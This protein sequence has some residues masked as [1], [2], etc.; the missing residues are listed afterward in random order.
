MGFPGGPEVIESSYNTGDL[1][2][3]PGLGRSSGERNGNP[4]QCSCLKNPKDRGA[5]WATVYEVAKS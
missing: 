5:L 1:G 3:I 2:S 4:L